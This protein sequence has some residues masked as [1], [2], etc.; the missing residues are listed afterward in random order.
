MRIARPPRHLLVRP[1]FRPS[2]LPSVRPSVRLSLHPV[3]RPYIRPSVPPFVPH[4]QV[5]Y[6]LSS[7]KKKRNLELE[8]EF[9]APSSSHWTRIG[10]LDY[11]VLYRFRVFITTSLVF[12][13][14]VSK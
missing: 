6:F 7:N 13:G 12:N 5:I 10:N 8:I 2:V 14:G 9:R 1:S 4:N 3:V 11:K